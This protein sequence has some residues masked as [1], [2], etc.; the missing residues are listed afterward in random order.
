MLQ[1]FTKTGTTVQW[2]RPFK[3]HANSPKGL[4]FLAAVIL[5]IFSCGTMSVLAQNAP[6]G[7]FIV[8]QNGVQQG[9]AYSTWQEAI[10]HSSTTGNTISQVKNDQGT[11]IYEQNKNNPK[12]WLYQA[13][14]NSSTTSESTASSWVY[15]YANAYVFYGNGTVYGARTNGK[16]TI[17]KKSEGLETGMT[18][19]YKWSTARTDWQ[20]M[21]ATLDLSQCTYVT[22]GYY[23]QYPG[24]NLYIYGQLRNS[25]NAGLGWAEDWGFRKGPQ[26]NVWHFFAAGYTGNYTIGLYD[27]KNLEWKLEDNNNRFAFYVDGQLIY[28]KSCNVSIMRQSNMQFLMAT[29]M[30]PDYGT[31]NTS[32]NDRITNFRDGTFLGNVKWQDCKLKLTNGTVWNFWEEDTQQAIYCN[33]QTT[34]LVRQG[35]SEIITLSRTGSFTPP[36]AAPTNDQCSNATNL[37]CA[38]N[39]TGQTTVGATAKTITGNTAS[40]YGVWYTFVGDGQ[41]TKI[42]STAGSGFDHKIVL[43]SGS[44]NN[45]TYINSVDAAGS[46]GTETYTFTPTSS[47]R[48]YVYIAHYNSTASVTQTGTFNISRTCTAPIVA[49]TVTTQAA[50]SIT[51]TTATLNKSVTAGSQTITAQGF[52]YR[53]SGTSSWNTSTTGNLSGLTANTTYQFRAYA[54]TAS[55]TTYGSILTFTTLVVPGNVPVND[56]CANATALSCGTSN[57]QGTTVGTTAKTIPGNT[58]SNYGVWYF[59][60][61][62]GLPTT[63]TVVPASNFDPRIV[64]FS[65]SCNNLTYVGDVDGRGAGGTETHTFTAT[66]GTRYYVYIAYYGTSGSSTQTGTF[67]ISKSWAIGN[68]TAANVTAT[69]N[70]GTLTIT[71]TGA[72]QDWYYNHT[73]LPWYCVKDEITSV[74]IDNGVTTIGKF[75]FLDCI[76]LTSI[77]IPS[78]VTSIGQGAFIACNNLNEITVNRNTPPFVDNDVFDRIDVSKVNLR[79]PAGTQCTYA[80]TSGWKDIILKQQTITFSPIPTQTYGNAAITLSATSTSGLTINYESSNTSVATVSG[81]ILTIKGAGTADITATQNGDCAYV[82]ATQII[83]TLT[84]NKAPVNADVIIEGWTYGAI[85]N[86][87]TVSN[88]PG[89]A[90][91]NYLYQVYSEADDFWYYIN[92]PT[93]TSAA[94]NYRVRA[95]ISE[96][97]NYA[98]ANPWFADFV[99]SKSPLTITAEDKTREQGQ[100]NPEFTFAYSGFKNGETAN[101]LDVLPTISCVANINSPA[102]FFDIVL[103]GGSDNNYQYTLVNGRLEVTVINGINNIEAGKISIYPNPTQND[104]FIKS[105]LPIEKVEIY[106]LTGTLLLFENNFNEKISVSALSQGVYLLKVYTDKGVVVSKIVKE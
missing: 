4:K 16:N 104:I 23:Q 87:P 64:I 3:E 82:A 62:D 39:L 43:F 93:N 105:D 13:N 41:E 98:F 50:T 38:A 61:G 9:S 106:S 58:A 56:L 69:F 71:G 83:R 57:L 14:F 100:V 74:V 65:G 72:M 90:P 60:D 49:P 97:D 10:Y 36:I 94:G 54:T 70:N 28:S 55:G 96:T 27:I 11:T 19:V 7:Q 22:P 47:T 91:V 51:Q 86:Q 20:S 26:D 44:C 52:E 79:V 21:T 30:C 32:D 42:T 46:G 37:S 15:T 75:A 34:Q 6:S 8:V 35:N 45:L 80:A 95:D 76:A 12:Y 40:K 68:P 1:K 2:W 67:S 102:G 101:V 88:N 63:I 73:S 99:I 81:N 103:S 29:T 48:Y 33:Q 77:T 89:S 24:N 84:V 5:T 59:F 92:A 18:Y 31:T 85:P 78:T 53:V 25:G 66:Y 17:Y